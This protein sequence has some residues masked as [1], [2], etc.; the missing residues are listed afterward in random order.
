M[1]ELFDCPIEQFYDVVA[2]CQLA[3]SNEARAWM[4]D[5]RLRHQASHKP[6]APPTMMPRFRMT[7][8]ASIHDTQSFS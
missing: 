3:W 8:L 6:T 5:A 2:S 1:S 7:S 4:F